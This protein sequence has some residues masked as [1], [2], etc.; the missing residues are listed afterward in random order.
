MEGRSG[1][2]DWRMSHR[3]VK[4]IQFV[5]HEE[6]VKPKMPEPV[7]YDRIILKNGDTI[8][9]QV[10][11]AAF[12]LTTFYGTLNFEADK[13]Q[14]INIQGDGE[15]VDFV[16]LKTGDRLSGTIE[17]SLIRIKIDSGKEVVVSKEKIKDVL[18]RK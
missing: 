13:I 11:T 10:L 7:H 4:A 14:Q 1:L 12:T 6:E 16:M 9:G 18:F 2:E 5:D 17:E 8:N 3:D 15:E